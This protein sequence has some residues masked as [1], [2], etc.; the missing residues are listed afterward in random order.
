MKMLHTSDWHLGQKFLHN[1]REE[2]HSLALDWLLEVIAE[3][4]IDLLVVAGDIFDIGNPPNYARRLYYRFLTRLLQTSCRYVVI[5]G[6]N[7]DSPSML[8]APRELLEVLNIWVIAAATGDPADEVIE[9]RNDSGEL[10]AVLAA[11]PFLRDADLKYS[12][13]GE[14]GYD[15]IARIREGIHSHYQTMAGLV[16]K[17]RDAEAPVIATGHLHVTGS[18]TSGRQNNIY[19]GDIE[20]IQVDQFPDVFDYIALGHIHRAQIMGSREHI[21]YSGSLIPLSFSE[22]VDD[23]QVWIVEF[24][25]N[26]IQSIQGRALP[27]FR[28]LKTIQ[29]DLD[30]VRQRLRQFDEKGER[31]LAP[32]VEVIVDADEILP[33]LDNELR[34]FTADMQLEVLKIKINR[35]YQGLAEQVEEPDL[36]TMDQLEVFQRKCESFGS[37]PEEMKELTE[38][39]RELQEWMRE[40]E[41]ADEQ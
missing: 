4:S 41:W 25:K 1:D 36:E 33:Q 32:W 31:Q 22:T 28:R 11:V 26:R 12:V 23:K 27:V 39:F 14:T 6:G 13:A 7:H 15:R 2:E 5:T 40:S 35:R 8:S 17:Y 9:L 38:T 18:E 24:E 30:T 10:E 19:I 37:T 20:N 3:E 21:R 29:G 16:E 34:A